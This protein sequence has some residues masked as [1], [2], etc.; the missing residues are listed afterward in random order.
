[1]EWIDEGIVIGVRRHGENNAVVE[2]MTQARGR[3][4]GLV[5]GGFSRRQAPVLQPGNKVRAVWRARVP[6][7]LGLFS[8]EPVEERAGRLMEAAHGAFGVTYMGTLLHLLPERDPHPGLYGVL[9]A[10]LDA[11]TEPLAAGELLARFELAM[12]GELGF[13]LELQSCAAT[14]G[15]NNLVFVSPR[16]GRA[17]SEDAGAPYADLLLPLPS[18]LVGSIV[19]PSVGDL[20]DAFRLTEYFLARRVFEPRG[21]SVPEARSGFLSALR[22]ATSR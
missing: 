1:M 3:H 7:Q 11:F 8:L 19:P 5:R 10:I 15:N 12:L 14:G 6:E 9:D 22:R 17:V 13:G 20:E 16:T 4:L 21:L 2:L 18:F